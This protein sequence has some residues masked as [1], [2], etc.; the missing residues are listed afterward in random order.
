MRK[1]IQSTAVA[2][3]VG[4][5]AATASADELVTTDIT[6]V[7]T[8]TADKTYNLQGQIF[9]DPGA[10]LIIDPGVVIA[11]DPGGSL[12]VAAGGE[13]F[14]NGTADNPVIFTS[15]A[16]VATWDPDGTHPT[17][18]DPTTGT[19]RVA[20]N[21]WGNLT[22]M[23]KGYISEDATPGNV[24]TPSASN[25]AA[26]EG[27]TVGGTK[28]QYGGGDDEDDS[29]SLSYVTFRYGGRVVTL[30]NELN[31][32][33]LG[34]I[35]RGTDISHV[36]IMN[37]VDDG[38]EIWGGTVNLKNFSIWN[39]GDDSLDFDQGWRG[40]AQFG[41]IVQGYSA[42]AKQGSG[43][44]DNALEMDGAENCT[45]QPVSSP[46]LYNMSVVGQP[47][48][49]DHGTSWR[50]N[51]RAQIRNSMF[52][53]IGAKV[54]HNNGDDTDGA[55]GY[56][57]EDPP[58]SGLFADSF[59]SLWTT[60]Y[61]SYFVPHAPIPP[62]T[63]GDLYKSMVDGSMIEIADTVFF[64]TPTAGDAPGPI[65]TL[66]NN[67]LIPGTD[68][69]DAP[70]RSITRGSQVD[71]S[72]S[73]TTYSMLPVEGLDPRAANEATTSVGAAPADGFF[74]PAQYRGA[75]DETSNWLY[76][77]SASVAFDFIEVPGLETIFNSTIAP[78]PAAMQTSQTT[79][80]EIGKTWDPALDHSG[81]FAP[82][83]L[84]DFVAISGVQ[85]DIPTPL[86]SILCGL[87]PFLVVTSPVGS[88]KTVF[89][90][91]IPPDD[92]NVGLTLYVQ[93]GSFTASGIQ[94]CDAIEITIGA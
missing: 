14:V 48:D 68:D 20:A 36:E 90:L 1:L 87:S 91:P 60:P 54:V 74:T 71:L 13:V 3:S 62:L 10:T 53:D 5:L 77:W 7:E 19:W 23:G 39:V 45:W 80:P 63:Y 42:D 51:C 50:D 58:G 61:N 4:A 2:A 66:A 69:A 6:G 17:G 25:V 49:G 72:A 73:G 32:L 81:G 57:G 92:I 46:V 75:F 93:G 24:P 67:V 43:V 82:T 94:F 44:G 9:V 84:V 31:G 56:G 89:A 12:A 8:W 41:L 30:Q 79:G 70:I 22:I 86:G 76:P 21:E 64:R 27:L 18:G 88:P 35:G 28:Q 11:S 29:G 78:N 65:F 34:G 83:A 15:K 16:D 40:K 85:S 38:I 55:C 37:N 26:M 52:M 33:S 47:L 59:A